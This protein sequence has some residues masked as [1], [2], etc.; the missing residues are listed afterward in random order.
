MLREFKLYKILYNKITGEV[1]K[2]EVEYNV[3]HTEEE[4][5]FHYGNMLMQ[6]DWDSKKSKYALYHTHWISEETG[7][8]FPI[9]KTV[10]PT[11][12]QKSLITMRK[13]S[14][15]LSKITEYGK[16]QYKILE[17]LEDNNWQVP[18]EIFV[19]WTG[20]EEET[21][22]YIESSPE[23]NPKEHHVNV[24][25]LVSELFLNQKGI[26][27]TEVQITR[28]KNKSE[29]ELLT[30]NIIGWVH[31]E[32]GQESKYSENIKNSDYE[33]LNYDLNQRQE[34]LNPNWPFKNSYEEFIQGV[35]KEFKK[36]NNKWKPRNQYDENGEPIT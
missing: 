36:K 30:D 26:S 3:F 35:K 8:R 2:M 13:Q 28:F 33:L 20:M 15:L 24:P 25:T 1:K 12:Y 5:I 23:Y 14:N 6:L 21:D 34:Y 4:A 29:L 9:T 10:S 16:Q 19:N 7:E 31:L 32:R 27:I 17:E 22:L 18:V 11:L